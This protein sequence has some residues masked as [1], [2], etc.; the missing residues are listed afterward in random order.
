MLVGL[1]GYVL[2][3]TKRLQNLTERIGM[4]IVSAAENNEAGDFLGLYLTANN[5]E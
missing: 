1:I 4:V 3:T 2:L 5:S